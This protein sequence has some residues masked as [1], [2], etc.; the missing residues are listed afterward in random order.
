MGR[1]DHRPLPIGGPVAFDLL[2]RSM[3]WLIIAELVV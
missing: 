1:G 2:D 3:L